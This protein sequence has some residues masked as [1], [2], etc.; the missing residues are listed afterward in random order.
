[1]TSVCDGLL[2]LQG[3]GYG[4]AVA[5]FLW[6]N[7]IKMQQ[8]ATEAL[9]HSDKPVAWGKGGKEETLPLSSSSRGDSPRIVSYQGKGVV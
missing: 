5:A 8:L 6:Y 3:V 1:M 4:V 7:H 2:C 9:P